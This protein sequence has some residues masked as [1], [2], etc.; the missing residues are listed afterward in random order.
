MYIPTPILAATNLYYSSLPIQ[1]YPISTALPY[2]IL[3][4]RRIALC[5]V[6]QL[7]GEWADGREWHV[8]EGEGG[9]SYS[10]LD[11]MAQHSR[12]RYL[13]ILF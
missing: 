4:L 8:R 12:G 1:N 6:T 10:A 7:R 13:T 9:G 2:A 11:N 5:P 3:A